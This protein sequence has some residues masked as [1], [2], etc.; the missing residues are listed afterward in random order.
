MHPFF[1]RAVLLSMGENG[2][3][4][5]GVKKDLVT[6]WKSV[7][8]QS[9]RILTT[10][11][12]ISYHIWVYIVEMYIIYFTRVSGKIFFQGV[13]CETLIPLQY[14]V[15]TSGFKSVAKKSIAKEKGHYDENSFIWVW[16]R[17]TPQ[18]LKTYYPIGVISPEFIRL[19][20]TVSPFAGSQEFQHCCERIR[21]N[22]KL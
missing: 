14:A 8:L 18:F 7:E 21:N 15:N 20:W 9:W 12:L 19:R 4:S 10:A 2:R 17:Y 11:P 13:S 3:W 5:Q 1:S 16:F 6:R 22:A